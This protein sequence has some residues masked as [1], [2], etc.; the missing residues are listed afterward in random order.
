[1]VGNG[2]GGYLRDTYYA[3]STAGGVLFGIPSWPLMKVITPVGALI[4]VCIGFFTMLFF[5]Y[6]FPYLRHNVTYSSSSKEGNKKQK[7]EKIDL[8]SS[9]KI[10]SF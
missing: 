2:Y 4:V 10:T 8:T 6:I 1:M 5:A 3:G 7:K 9:P